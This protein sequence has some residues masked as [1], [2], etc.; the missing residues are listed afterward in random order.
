MN[1]AYASKE[2]EHWQRRSIFAYARELG[3]E[4]DKDNKNDSLHDTVESLTGKRSIGQLTFYEAQKVIDCL[5]G[6]LKG[7]KRFEEKPKQ[8][9]SNS[10]TK[11]R[12]DLY[13][14][15]LGSRPGMAS[16]GQ[17]EFIRAMMFEL[18]KRDPGEASL[19]DRLRGWLEKYQHRSDIKFLTPSK[20][21]EAIEGLKSYLVK[22][23]WE[24]K[25]G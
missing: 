21:N 2:I 10:R 14:F 6:N 24:Y 9:N 1:R 25:G 19:E 17:L 3:I 11:S 15:G 7:F 5:K 18:K 20:A 23:G 8:S 12:W 13:A 4:I 22:L 16:P